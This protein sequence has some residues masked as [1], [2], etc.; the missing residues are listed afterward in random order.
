MAGS[1]DS[2]QG[3]KVYITGGSTTTGAWTSTTN[4]PTF[5]PSTAGMPTANTISASAFQSV[6]IA[7][8]TSFAPTALPTVSYG[9]V[10]VTDGAGNNFFTVNKVNGITVASGSSYVPQ[11]KLYANTF[12]VTSTTTYTSYTGSSTNLYSNT[13][14]N[15]VATSGL[16]V[17]GGVTI[18]GNMY[19]AGTWN[20]SYFCELHRLSTNYIDLSG[21]P[22]HLFCR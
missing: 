3:G 8:G 17:T 7:P 12:A 18:F 16:R 2:G 10:A 9:D 4:A 21:I 6:I 19:F 20:F 22:L 11:I 5:A 14:V 15:I 13:F 1:G